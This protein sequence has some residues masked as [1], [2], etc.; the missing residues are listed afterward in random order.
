MQLWWV[1]SGHQRRSHSHSHSA[2]VAEWRLCQLRTHEL[3]LVL[4]VLH[5]WSGASTALF[6]AEETH[7][8]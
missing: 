1:C 3:V 7:M 5:C 2:K 4:S 8:H 6:G